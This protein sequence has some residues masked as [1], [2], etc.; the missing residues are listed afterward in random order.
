MWQNLPTWPSRLVPVILQ[1]RT[2]HSTLDEQEQV[3]E[4]LLSHNS[5]CHQKVT[6]QEFHF[7][8]ANRAVLKLRGPEFRSFPSAPVNCQ[9]SSAEVKIASHNWWNIIFKS[10]RS[11]NQ[12]H[13]QGMANATYL[14]QNIKLCAAPVANKL[15]YFCI[16]YYPFVFEDCN[17]HFM[18]RKTF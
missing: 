5:F 14:L 9:S 8:S 3:W 15:C 18:T 1:I 4:V 6:V 11:A 12:L 16:F 13:V 10:S 7:A 2:T 17:S